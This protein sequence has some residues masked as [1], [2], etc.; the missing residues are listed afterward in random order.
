[1]KKKFFILFLLF[2]IPGVIYAQQPS[3]ETQVSSRTV[4]VGEPFRIIFTIENGK[5]VSGFQAPTFKGFDVLGNSSSQS[6]S[7]INGN[8]SRKLSYIYILRASSVGRFTIAGAKVRVNG[9]QLTSN[10]VTITVEKG[11]NNGQRNNP[12]QQHPR[13]SRS[14]SQ[15]P[16][17]PYQQR[18]QNNPAILQKGEDP[19][20]KIKKNLFVR[21]DVDK[22]DV[23]VGQQII[24]NYK[25]FTRIPASSKIVK[26]P[27]FSGFSTHDIDLGNINRPSTKVIDGEKYRVY[28][29]RKTIMFPLQSGTQSLDPVKIENDVKL[30]SIEKGSGNQDPFSQMFNDPFFKQMFDD[31]FFKRA[32][33]AGAQLVPHEYK[34]NMESPVVKIHV[35][36]LPEKGKP[37]NFDGAVG[38]FSIHSKIDKS[39]LTTDDAVTFTVTI[40]GKGNIDMLSAPTIPFPK[41]LESYDPKTKD[42][43]NKTNPFGGSRTFTYVLMP[44]ATGKMTI[45]SVQFSY[46][47][48]KSKAYKTIHTQPYDITVTPG[49]KPINDSATNSEG[50]SSQNTLAP[51][52]KGNL[53][54]EKVGTF[55]FGTWWH[56]ILMILPI[57]LLTGLLLWKRQN[58]KLRANQV[59]LKNKKAN[60]VALKRLSLAK[61]YLR[62][63]KNKL[64]YEEV[65]HAVWG[66]LCDKLSIP[67][68]ELTKQKA[69]AELQKKE[70][71]EDI[72]K[73]LFKLLDRCEMA[74]YAGMSGHE[75]MENTFTEAVSVISTL[76]RKL[77][78]QK[79]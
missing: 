70:V 12:S 71:P 17:S 69:E 55:W 24:A 28:T 53:K 77:K 61:K 19:M 15:Q 20:K 72:R 32:F 18:I 3:F 5:K 66:Y 4:G 10:P 13:Q 45:P 79:H 48:P 7:I 49:K 43:F 42:N 60:R 50:T 27:S 74:L 2:L 31:P 54:W 40:S 14:P 29:F 33:G 76:E 36:P 26:V 34:Y 39:N 62:K 46:F 21:V 38:H 22:K 51:I 41:K 37:D 75:H 8:T 23:F 35:K 67:L 57:L 30:Y 47:D 65:S 73:G 52:E 11:Q 44:N 59:L 63:N 68:S 25:L 16:T 9:D 64:F 56:W 1:M 78:K 6:I 58:D